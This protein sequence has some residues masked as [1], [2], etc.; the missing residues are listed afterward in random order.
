MMS[1]TWAASMSRIDNII[2]FAEVV[3]LATKFLLCGTIRG[4]VPYEAIEK[5]REKN[6]GWPGSHGYA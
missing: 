2:E 3:S 4:K 6:R 5:T 1:V